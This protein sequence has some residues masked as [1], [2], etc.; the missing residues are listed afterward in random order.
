MKTTVAIS[1]ILIALLLVSFANQKKPSAKK[2]MKILDNFCQY[3][4]SGN[5]VIDGDTTS[6]QSFY[7]SQEIS[8]FQYAEFLNDLKK[9]GELAKLATAQ[10]DTNLWNTALSGQNNKYADYYHGHPAYRDYPVVNITKEGAELY[11]EWLTKKYAE[12]SGGEM[13]LKFR[14]PTRVEW[15][16]AARGSNHAYLYAWGGPLLRNSEGVYRANFMQVGEW[17]LTRNAETGLPELVSR[18]NRTYSPF[19]FDNSDVTAP[20][21]SYLTNEFGLS[22][23]NGNV[24]EMISDGDKAVGGH[25]M[26]L[27]FDIRNESVQDF[28]EAHPTV[29]FRVV[30]SHL[31]AIGH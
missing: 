4:P 22:N 3:V 6:V 15:V 12:M 2:A 1:T 16:R 18:E 31:A 25:W 20:S 8:N 10:I 7:M 24:A 27:G 5:A 19:M 23:M 29:G 11:C 30:A 21:G 28:K 14:I 17:N 9:N 26:S 13:Q